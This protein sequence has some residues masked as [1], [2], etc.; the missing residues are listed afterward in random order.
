MGI[1]LPPP[2]ERPNPYAVFVRTFLN[3]RNA[4]R[5]YQEDQDRLALAKEA[6][7]RANEEQKRREKQWQLDFDHKKAEFEFQQ[8]DA[9]RRFKASEVDRK[10]ERAKSFR[11]FRN[12]TPGQ[13][14]SLQ[15]PTGS[16]PE[17]PTMDV[18][19]VTYDTLRG[20]KLSDDARDF[21]QAKELRSMPSPPIAIPEGLNIP[22]LTPGTSVDP[23]II[24]AATSRANNRD[25]IAAAERRFDVD[26]APVRMLDIVGNL[27]GLL[28][29][30]TGVI[31]PVGKGLR[32]AP[33]PKTELDKLDE[34]IAAITAVDAIEE[35]IKAFQGTS[36][37]HPVDKALAGMKLNSTMDALSR[38]VGRNMG[39]KGVFTDRDKEDF[40]KFFGPGVVFS[41]LAP[42]EQTKRIK[43]ARGIIT[44]LN[45]N[46]IETFYK[47]YGTLP[48]DKMQFMNASPDSNQSDPGGLFSR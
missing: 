29:R 38:T 3:A 25:S 7:Q 31:T 39:E 17:G 45:K 28:N 8:M 5:Q 41:V 21:D 19:P 14:F 27:T 43:W 10:W 20:D 30:K 35:D 33:V 18:S 13:P 6:E 24:G 36:L 44:R 42:D 23:A 34:G 9:E 40:K 4:Q 48:E 47:R 22:G 11:D 12:T 46:R 37:A 2:V 16:D 1:G 32:S 26:N 15:L